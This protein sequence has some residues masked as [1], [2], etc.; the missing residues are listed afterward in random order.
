MKVLSK[1]FDILGKIIAIVWMINF[2]LV[3]TNA[4]F[5]YIHVDI[6]LKIMSVIS[7]WGA[8]I[9]VAVV[10]F[11]ASSKK[12]WTLIPFLI[13]LAFCVIMM[14]FPEVAHSFGM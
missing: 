12:L 4:K 1:I 5:D 10:G 9:L 6:V 8:L 3:V 2:V 11:E 14:F 13:V 7:T